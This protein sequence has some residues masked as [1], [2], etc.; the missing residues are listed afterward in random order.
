MGLQKAWEQEG[1]PWL[2]DSQ[3]CPS[4]TQSHI[5]TS[6]RGS[7]AD[8]PFLG[9][10]AAHFWGVWAVPTCCLTAESHT[11]SLRMTEATGGGARSSWEG[12]IA[13][14]VPESLLAV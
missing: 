8:I 14:L 12:R 4:P 3:A 2:W 10:R 7:Q 9:S 5:C 11:D 6:S 1:L 13:F